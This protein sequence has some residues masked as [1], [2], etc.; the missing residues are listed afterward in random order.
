MVERRHEF[1]NASFLGTVFPRDIS[2]GQYPRKRAATGGG[3]DQYPVDT[4]PPGKRSCLRNGCADRKTQWVFDDS[5][6]TAFDLGH[7]VDLFV[8]ALTTMNDAEAAFE[9]HRLCHFQAGDAV[10]I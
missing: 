2:P 7:Y 3:L 1:F 10:H 6:V 4:V 9:C 5:T 8:D